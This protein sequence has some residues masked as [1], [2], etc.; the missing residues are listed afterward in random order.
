MSYRVLVS[1][2]V[3]KFLEALDKKSK[4][5]CKDNLMKLKS[6]YPI[7]GIGDKERLPFRGKKVYRLHIS[8]TWTAFY[9]IKEEE[10]EVWV[11]QILPIDEAHKKYG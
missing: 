5:I 2:E 10:K 3:K 1:P 6:P 7:R 8:H 9:L 11:E 4:R